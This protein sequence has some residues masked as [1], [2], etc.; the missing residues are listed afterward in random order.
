MPID[1][2]DADTFVAFLDI[3]G[4]KDLMQRNEG[5]EALDIFYREGYHS[6]LHQLQIQNNKVEGIFIS[7]CGV[8]FVRNIDA[9][10]DYSSQLNVL[11]RTIKTINISML[12]NNYMLTASIAYGHF[13]Y[14]N[15]L[16]LDGMDKNAL[17]GNAYLS[18]FLDNEIGIPRIQPG[19]CRI[20][21]RGLPND[22][23]E[24]IHSSE[25]EPFSLIKSR[26]RDNKHFYYYWMAEDENGI[27]TFEQS[28]LNSYKLKFGGMIEALRGNRIR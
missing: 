2:Y 16:N 8:L 11:L 24:L 19:Q 12:A 5:W 20:V 6:I 3:S 23:K 14:Q 10:N 7:D 9:N 15:R 28:Y 25:V 13:K 27:D 1:N 22:I 4:F 18:A 26:M 21:E 17:Y